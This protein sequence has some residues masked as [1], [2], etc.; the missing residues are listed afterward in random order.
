MWGMQEVWHVFQSNLTH[1]SLGRFQTGEG[2]LLACQETKIPWHNYI[3]HSISN[4]TFWCFTCIIASVDW[5]SLAVEILWGQI[6]WKTWGGPILNCPCTLGRPIWIRPCSGWQ[7]CSSGFPLGLALWEI[8]WSSPASPW[9]TPFIPPILLG[10]TQ[11]TIVKDGI[12]RFNS[13]NITSKQGYI[14]QYTP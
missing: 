13:F 5:N 9:K 1:L 11:Y 2:Q 7:G 8:P 12:L 6:R 3:R 4:R 14:L 10:L